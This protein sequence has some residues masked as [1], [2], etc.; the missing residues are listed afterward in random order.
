MQHILN[1]ILS[2]LITFSIYGQ[3]RVDKP[4]QIQLNGSGIFLK[5]FGN[6]LADSEIDELSI[7][8]WTVP[9][10]SIGY[11]LNKRL[12]LGYSFQPNRNLILKEPWT[13]GDGENDGM[14]NL[15]H[16]TGAFHSIESRYFPFKF[17]LYSSF[18]LTHISKA[19][20]NMTFTRTSEEMTIGTNSYQTDI[21]ADWNFK[22]LN[23]I[24]IG[25]GYNYVHSSG[26]SFD[27][28]IGLPLTTNNPLYQNI[29]I[30]P[31][32]GESIEQ[33]DIESGKNKIENE[34]FFFPVQL[35]LNF[36]Y[37]FKYK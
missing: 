22:S 13:F 8:K 30:N 33:T 11:H 37:N 32:G 7:N 31:V 9:G 25:L 14:I 36:G 20:Y 15:N 35:H 10:I 5:A 2:L 4:F 17:D 6:S 28:G 29:E 16:N 18:F 19:D 3:H 26:I 23:T 21:N 24:G 34:L 12:Y 27:F 1:L